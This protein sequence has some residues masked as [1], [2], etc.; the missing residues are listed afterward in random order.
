MAD[1]ITAPQDIK[2]LPEQLLG[3]I[4][5]AVREHLCVN[6]FQLPDAE[7]YEKAQALGVN[8]H[9]IDRCLTRSL[10]FP[11]KKQYIHLDNAA[12]IKRFGASDFRLIESSCG[13]FYHTTEEGQKSARDAV[14]LALTKKT[15]TERLADLKKAISGMVGDCIRTYRQFVALR[16]EV[17]MFTS[18]ATVTLDEE[19]K[20]RITLAHVP[21]PVVK[22]DKTINDDWRE[23][24][25]QFPELIDLIAAARF[26]PDRKN[27]Y[28]FLQA[29]SDFG[30]GL[31]FGKN[32]AFSKLGIVVEVNEQELDAIVKGSAS[33]RTAS[34]F[35]RALILAINE[36]ERIT[37]KS[38][39]LESAI[40][41]STKH[42][43]AQTVPL[44]T[45]IYTSADP[46]PGLISESGIDEQIARR[47]SHIQP[48]SG[49]VNDRPLFQA[50]PGYYAARVQDAIAKGLNSRIESYQQAG[51]ELASK[52]AAEYLNE[53]HKKYGLAKS[54]GVITDH[55]GDICEEFYSF[56][57]YDIVQKQQGLPHVTA[58]NGIVLK[59]IAQWW[60][61]FVCAHTGKTSGHE[62]N[63][64]IR[65][66]VAI[67]GKPGSHRTKSG[68]V[69]GTLIPPLPDTVASR[70]TMRAAND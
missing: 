10:W 2:Q 25:P 57:H 44:Y 15:A 35:V 30:K 1:I 60:R 49:P 39:V 65:D 34:E 47:F 45:K 67:I 18:A 13:G 55:Y 21:Y 7:R 46:I 27:A 22:L 17:D 16:V 5:A 59:C 41:V 51:P 53:F 6:L 36:P 56:A 32:G 54:S 12:H 33:G 48:T 69:K 9:A 42:Q 19:G 58:E 11:E 31:L 38:F 43:I 61:E 20:A 28:L 50:D 23:H 66:R 68:V 24:F 70:M 8:I 37:K 52:Q 62:F 3:K 40:T 63:T 26:A 64:L 29:V 4:L 14:A